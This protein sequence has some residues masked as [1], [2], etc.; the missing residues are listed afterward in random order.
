MRILFI[1]DI[2]ARPGRE[3]IE[4][5]LPKIIKENKIDFVV[6]N[7]E[8]LA[9]GRGATKIT[10][11]AMMRAGINY[12]T[13]GDHIFWHQGFEDDIEKLPVVR[14]ANFTPGA[15]GKDYEIVDAG[16]LGNI[17][18]F[19]LIGRVSFTNNLVDDPFRRADEILEETKNSDL[20]FSILDFHAE[21]TSEKYALAHY[22]DG[23]I[24]A[25]IGT[26][27]HVPT[28]D[29]LVLPRKTLYISDV[30]MTG[31]IDSVIG[32]KKEIIINQFL[33]GQ[34][35]KF[36]WE[37]AGTKAFRSVLLDTER[38]SIERLR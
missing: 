21:A 8:N 19:N 33:T 22:L 1:G 10:L 35:Q 31:A 29:N 20:A 23:R 15:A 16:K 5:L 13:S 6:A 24:G 32:V 27:T 25:V 11:E 30:G 17:L 18:I 34:H 3:L 12:F 9:H 7:A 36:E 28:C 14:P 2:V 37:N 4:E 38:N 26:H